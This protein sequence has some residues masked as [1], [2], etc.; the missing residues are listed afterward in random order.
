[1]FASASSWLYV[2]SGGF[3][4]DAHYEADRADV[5]VTLITLPKLRKLVVD[6]YEKLDS[7]TRA[8]VPLR[9]LYWPQTRT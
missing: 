9:R 4:K 1:L 5:A 6:L 7:E 8:L 2:S 3:T